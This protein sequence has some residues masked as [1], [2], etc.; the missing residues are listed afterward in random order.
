MQ[1]LLC[2]KIYELLVTLIYRCTDHYLYMYAF[3]YK[4][5]FYK[6]RQAEIGKKI[7]Q[8]LSNTLRLN[9][10]YLKIIRF[11]YPRY[12]PKIIGNTLKNVQKTSTPVKWVYMI[13]TM[14]VRLKMKNRPIHGHKCTKYKICLSIMIVICIK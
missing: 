4:Q 1:S 10:C 3:F 8:K 11:L 5:H 9:F 2:R 13:M 14:K 6:Q 12:H 7:K